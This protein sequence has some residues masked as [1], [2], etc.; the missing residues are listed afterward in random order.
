MSTA[1]ASTSSAT[2]VYPTAAIIQQQQQTIPVSAAPASVNNNAA[3]AA[4]AAQFA[5]YQAYV[6]LSIMNIVK[7]NFEFPVKLATTICSDYCGNIVHTIDCHTDNDF[8]C[9]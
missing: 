7:R 6:S 4:Y 1:V 5:Q 2:S 8:G 3:Y 9:C